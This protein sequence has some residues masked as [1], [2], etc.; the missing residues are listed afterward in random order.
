MR[1]YDVGNKS[2]HPAAARIRPDC[3]RIRIWAQACA[4]ILDM[5]AGLRQILGWA[6]PLTAQVNHC[7][8]IHVEVRP[9]SG[10]QS[11]LPSEAHSRWGQAFC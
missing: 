9:L 2:H 10:G 7:S 1:G 8:K 6:L 5:G 11:C 4:A 3:A